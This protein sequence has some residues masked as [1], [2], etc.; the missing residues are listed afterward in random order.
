MH[1]VYQKNGEFRIEM[2]RIITE[3]NFSIN[4]SKVRL[5]KNNVRQEVTG[6]TVNKMTNVSQKYIKQLRMW[7]YYWETY[8][9]N[10]A[11]SLFLQSYIK[12]K[13]H[14]KNAIPSPEFM[15]AVIRGKLNYLSM[16]KGRENTTYLKLKDRFE[17]LSTQYLDIEKI[18]NVWETEGI[19]NAINIYEKIV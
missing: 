18:L 15:E 10:K 19:E 6:I 5:Q 14:V 7:L 2:E 17:K 12:D 1:N 8:G 3:Q 13:S 16:V 4:Q 11:L 9:V